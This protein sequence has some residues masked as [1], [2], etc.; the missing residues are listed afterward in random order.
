[1][2]PWAWI[3]A[4][5]VGFALLQLLVYRYLGRKTRVTTSPAAAEASGVAAAGHETAGDATITC[6]DCGAVNARERGYRYCRECAA[7]LD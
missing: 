3:A 4:Y 2:N 5:V 7:T 1:M 6:G